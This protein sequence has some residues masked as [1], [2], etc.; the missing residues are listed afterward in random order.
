MVD[1]E[2]TRKQDKFNDN[3]TCY[4]LLMNMSLGGKN[5]VV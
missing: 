5:T 4:V 2:V 1:Y 3:E